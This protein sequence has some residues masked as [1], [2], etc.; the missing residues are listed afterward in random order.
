M[1]DTDKILDY[2]IDGML[3][4][5]AFFFAPFLT[6]TFPADLFEGRFKKPATL[7]DEWQLSI[8]RKCA[9][10]AYY[11]HLMEQSDGDDEL[12]SKLAGVA[13]Y[14]HIH[15]DFG[16]DDVQRSIFDRTSTWFYHRIPKMAR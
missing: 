14:V 6:R 11:Q 4:W 16:R 2:E 3:S 5:L 8:E 15:N 9:A 7:D 10:A 12:A 13:R 1:H